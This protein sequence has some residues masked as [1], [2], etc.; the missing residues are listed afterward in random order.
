MAEKAPKVAVVT[1]GHQYDV[2][3][4]H[5]LFRSLEGLDV[6]IQHMDDFA[7]SPVEVRDAYDSVVFYIMLMDTP[8]AEGLPW[9]AGNPKE[10]LEHLGSTKQGIVVLHHAILAYPQWSVWNEL[11]GIGDRSFDY[12][13]GEKPHVHVADGD[14]PITAGLSDWEMIDETYTMADAGEDSRVVLT[15]DHPKSMKTIAWTRTYRNSPVFCYQNGHD[16]DTWANP[17][18]REVL[19]RGILWSAGREDLI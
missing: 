17:N 1:G 13:I 6:Y 9:Y 14:H 12:H 16:N 11:V 7:S 5:R 2:L 15:V 19:R 4:F 3:N 10:A 18:F 8:A